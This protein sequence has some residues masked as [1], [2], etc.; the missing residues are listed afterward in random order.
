MPDAEPAVSAVLDASA[1]LAYLREEPGAG[2]VADALE[3]GAAISAV[4]WAE[5]LSKVAEIGQSP[6]ALADELRS[7]GL[8]GDALSLEPLTDQDCVTIAE[9]RPRTRALGLSLGDRA[10][11]ALGRRLGARILTTDRIWARLDEAG[12]IEIIRP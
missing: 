3:G 7:I 4:N 9:L 8:L 1:L 6:A 5:V 10:C 12:Q 2:I 11:L